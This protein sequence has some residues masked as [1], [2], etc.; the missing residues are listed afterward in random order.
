M[1][2]EVNIDATSE[3][4]WGKDEIIAD[5][6]RKIKIQADL[7]QAQ[8]KAHAYKV[9]MLEDSLEQSELLMDMHRKSKERALGLLIAQK[10]RTQAT[11]T[12]F[13]EGT[14]KAPQTASS[15]GK[16]FVKTK[17]KSTTTGTKPIERT[18]AS[19]T[20]TVRTRWVGTQA[21]DTVALVDMIEYEVR[22]YFEDTDDGF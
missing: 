11:Q 20:K 19:Q 21:D 15:A 9:S 10:T 12:S 16:T 3:E 7:I 2:L 18:V 4:D 1:S 5:L 14:N 13:D 17:E 22:H 6:H 8:A